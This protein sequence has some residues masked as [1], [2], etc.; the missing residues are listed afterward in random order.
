MRHPLSRRSLLASLCGASA[1]GLVGLR[2][3]GQEPPRR[4]V[5]VLADGGW[6]TSFTFDPKPHLTDGGPW[7]DEL[8][9]LEQLVTYG[10]INLSHNV[11]RRPSVKIFF[12]R[13]ADRTAVINGLWVG[14][15]SHWQAML[16]VLTGTPDDAS[17]DVAAIAGATLGSDRPLALVDLGGQSRFGPYAP[18]C[19]RSGVRA[20]FIGLLDPR[21][22]MTKADGSPRPDFVPTKDERDLIASWLQQREQEARLVRG[23]QPGYVQVLDERWSALDRAERLRN[24]P[25]VALSLPFGRRESLASQVPFTVDLLQSG[26]C[27]AVFLATGLPWDT[28]ADATRQHLYWQTTFFG[29][30]LLAT[31]LEEAG[32][33]EDTLVIVVTEI[34]RTPHRNLQNGTDHWTFT[35]ALAFGAGV[36]GMRQIG[37]TDDRV[38]GLPTDPE[39]GR[40]DDR[41]GPITYGSFA[42]GVLAGVGIDPGPFLPGVSPLRGFLT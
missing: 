42:A 22:R 15:L 1:T 24:T 11:F 36:D 37:G 23:D 41:Y 4:L 8:S 40:V 33:L 17:P 16:Q 20:Q 13:W 9:D 2:A 12:D 25:D 18:M 29:L 21:F 35:G 28:H 31:R 30:D 19:A 27:H 10:E 32:L 34:G 6:D 39:T 7:P 38:V 26:L 14:S 3:R 5:Y